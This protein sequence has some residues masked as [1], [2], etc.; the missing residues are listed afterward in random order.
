M[1]RYFKRISGVGNGSY[2]YFS[3]SKG[4]FDEKVNSMTTSNHIH[5]PKLSYYVTETRVEF[6]GSCLKQDEITY[7]HWKIVNIYIVFEITQNYNISDYSTLENC[8]FGT[9]TLTKNADIDKCKYSGYGIGFDRHWFFSYPS[10][11]L[12]EI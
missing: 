12:E 7:E 10:V 8:L 1:Y 2:I 3:K 5:T 4:L 6:S 9:V 11:E